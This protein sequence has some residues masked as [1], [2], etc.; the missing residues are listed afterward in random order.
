MPKVR[1][2]M[3]MSMKSHATLK[4]GQE[5]AFSLVPFELGTWSEDNTRNGFMMKRT[6]NHFQ[7]K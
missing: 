2:M 3:S 5:T 7:R 1:L 6:D 4:I